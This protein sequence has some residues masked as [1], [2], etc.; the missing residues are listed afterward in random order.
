MLEDG[1]ELPKSRQNF[2][3]YSSIGNLLGRT[4]VHSKVH[5][6]VLDS[7][8]NLEES[9]PNK[10]FMYGETGWKEGGKFKPHKTHQNG[11]SVDFMVSVLKSGKSVYLPTSP[12]N[13]F[14]YNVEFNTH[15]E[16]EKY[17]IDFEAI[18]AHLYEL[19]KETKAQGIEIWRVIFAPELQ[20]LLFNTEYGEYLKTNLQF[21]KK[22]SWVRHDE[23]YHVDFKMKCKKL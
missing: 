23:H 5:K 1:V 14:G 19:H 8:K 12:F 9:Y 13:K 10:V 18:S 7:Y 2:Q 21:S 20:P 6:V 11:L 4:Y 17:K 3:T 15:G 22:R 16:F